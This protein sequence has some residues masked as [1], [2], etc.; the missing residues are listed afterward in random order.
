MFW[1]FGLCLLLELAL[2]CSCASLVFACGGF[3]VYLYGFGLIC[4]CFVVC[5]SIFPGIFG[6]ADLPSIVL[7]RGLLVV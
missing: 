3:G 4:L 5:G 2:Y 6:L 1:C 7:C